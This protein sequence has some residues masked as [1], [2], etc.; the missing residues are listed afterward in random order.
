[1]TGK[2]E[3][4]RDVADDDNVAGSRADKHGDGSYVGE[5]SPDDDLSA[6][7]TGAEARSN[8]Q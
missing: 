1:M 2:D 5:K 8:A 3:R 4:E 6:G 7:I